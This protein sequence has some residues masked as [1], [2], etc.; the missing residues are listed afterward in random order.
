MILV[1]LQ[2]PVISS[3]AGNLFRFTRTVVEINNLSQ[4]IIDDLQQKQNAKK[5]SKLSFQ[6]TI[7]HPNLFVERKIWHTCQ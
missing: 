3:K 6:N 1:Y 7:N 4:M 5:L 2:K